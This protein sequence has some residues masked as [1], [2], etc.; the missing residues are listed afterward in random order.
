L[1]F[2]ILHVHTIP[3]YRLYRLYDYHADYYLTSVHVY[4]F[5][6]TATVISGI[7]TYLWW[8]SW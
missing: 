3:T 4:Q 8:L 6:S 1:Y 2:H 7:R 5:M